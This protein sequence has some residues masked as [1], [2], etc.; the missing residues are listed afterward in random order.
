MSLR[1]IAYEI[2]LDV[3][4]GRFSR[5]EALEKYRFLEAEALE[6]MDIVSYSEDGK[7]VIKA[8]KDW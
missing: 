4:N 3:K 1:K 2:A 8:P 6:S 7:T 5:Q